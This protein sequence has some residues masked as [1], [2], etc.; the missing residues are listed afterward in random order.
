MNTKGQNAFDIASEFGDLA[1]IDVV[2][3]YWKAL[4]PPPNKKRRSGR[5]TC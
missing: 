3:R 2:E 5:S 4:P 1:I